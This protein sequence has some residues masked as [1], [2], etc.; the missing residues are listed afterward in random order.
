MGLPQKAI[1]LMSG[2]TVTL[3][4]HR[5][6]NPNPCWRQRRHPQRQQRVQHV[7]G[8]A[9]GCCTQLQTLGDGSVFMCCLVQRGPEF[10]GPRHCR[11]ADAKLSCEQWKWLNIRA[12]GCLGSGKGRV[13]GCSQQIFLLSPAVCSLSSRKVMCNPWTSDQL[14][15][16]GHPHLCVFSLQSWAA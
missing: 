7:T 6:W 1:V 9:F 3:W 5:G 16:G 14:F 10:V 12:R 11:K 13:S 2:K 8:S 4:S 15:D